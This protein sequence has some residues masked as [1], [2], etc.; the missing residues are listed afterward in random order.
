MS[1][2]FASILRKSTKQINT[3]TYTQIR[4][5]I[6][7]SL[8]IHKKDMAKNVGESYNFPKEEEKIL[9]LWKNIDAF[10]TSLKLSEGKPRYKLATINQGP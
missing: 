5:G 4:R 9:D 6:S 7:S 2:V 10:K 3:T 1:S 8:I